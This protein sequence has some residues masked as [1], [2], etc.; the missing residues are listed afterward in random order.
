[1]P[2]LQHGPLV[3]PDPGIEQTFRRRRRGGNVNRPTQIPQTPI[4]N[5]GDANPP[6]PP[7]NTLH[8]A[9]DKNRKIRD[10]A[11]PGFNQ[12]LS[13]IAPPNMTA[14]HFELKPVMFEMIQTMGQF[15]G[16]PYEDPHS[17]LKSFLEIADAFSLN[18]VPEEALRLKLFPFTLR[19][20]A[21]AWLNSQAPNSITTWKDLAEKFLQKYFPPTRNVKL[22]NDIL[23]FRQE[24][25]HI[26]SNW[27]PFTMVSPM[28]PKSS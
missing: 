10:Y 9:D 22:R 18:G 20:R 4:E 1:M 6:P 19:D 25:F 28:L 23:L 14:T 26:A 11:T 13:G 16:L 15:G 21:K 24:T 17:H 3:I 27:K 5:M 8:V 2:R 12:L 7:E